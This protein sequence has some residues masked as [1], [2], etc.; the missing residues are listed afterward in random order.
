MNK[1]PNIIPKQKWAIFTYIG[2]KTRTITKLFQNTNIRIAYKTKKS[3]T[4]PPT[5]KNPQYW[6]YNKSG[7]HQMKCNSCQLGY[8]GQTRRNFKAR[9][10]EHIRSIRTN[11]LNTKY[12]QHI[13][14]TQHE[15]GPI[16]N[17]MDILH[18]GREGQLINTW[19]RFH[20][21][22]FSS[23]KLQLNDTCAD[24]HNPIFNLIKS[25]CK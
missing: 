17:T 19:E 6:Q 15:N 22:K 20:I 2:K 12:A 18:I 13:P 9:Y 25:H 1:T 5:A 16:A 11:N 14:D 3:Y 21:C 24:T 7:I 10:K 23:N 8:M 4:E